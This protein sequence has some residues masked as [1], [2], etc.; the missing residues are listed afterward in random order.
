VYIKP[1]EAL[2]QKV[3]SL[4]RE[5]LEKIYTMPSKEEREDN[6]AVLFKEI[7]EG[8]APEGYTASA[9]KEALIGLEESLVRK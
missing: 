7:V 8:L 3:E 4:A 9:V 5:R 6:V 2:N 1:D